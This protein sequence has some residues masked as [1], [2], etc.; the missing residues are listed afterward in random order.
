MGLH[1]TGQDVRLVAEPVLRKRACAHVLNE[2]PLAAR[3]A[4]LNDIA[5]MVA[6]GCS[7]LLV[8]EAGVGKSRLLRAALD[9]AASQAF[10]AQVAAAHESAASIF[11]SLHEWLGLHASAERDPGVDHPA[12]YLGRE[13][14]GHKIIL[15]IDDAHLLHPDIVASLYQ[16]ATFDRV[17]LIITVRPGEPTPE[18]I[19]KLWLDR[20]VERIEIKPFTRSAVG[21]VLSAKL[22]SHV[23]VE[24]VKRM[25]MMTGG[26]A[27]LLMELVDH[28]IAEGSLRP[29]NGIWRWAGFLP[30]IEGRLVEVVRSRLGDL[31]PDEAELIH[32][33]ALAESLEIDL[34]VVS[35]LT[36]AAESL[37]RRGVMVAERCGARLNVRLAYPL[38]RHVLAATMP[39]LTAYRLRLRLT[40]AI[41]QTER[42]SLD[43]RPSPSPA[44]IVQVAQARALNLVLGSHRADKALTVIDDALKVLSEVDARPLYA[45]QARFRILDDRFR[46][47]AAVGEALLRQ[48]QP[49]SELMQAMAPTVAF[50]HNAL[51]DSQKAL[52]LLDQCHIVLP[53]W[54]DQNWQRHQLV[55]AQATLMAGRCA[56]AHAVLDGLRQR[57]IADDHSAEYMWFILV[58]AQLDR[59]RGR[60]SDAAEQFRRASRLSIKADWLTSRVWILA[61][62]AGT[63][64][65]AGRL[66]E[67]S[68]TLSEARVSQD[69]TSLCPMDVDGADLESAV[70]L[71]QTDQR[72]HAAILARKVAQRCATAGRLTQAISALHLAA[73]V[74][75]ARFVVDRCAQLASSVSSAVLHA[76]ADHVLALANDDADALI[77]IGD[78]FAQFDM[79]PLAAEAAAQSCAAYRKTRRLHSARIAAARCHR[80]L[81]SYDIRLPAWVTFGTTPAHGSSLGLTAREHEI[82]GYAAT[83]LSNREIADRLT[84]SVRT[85]EN[86]LQRTYNKLGIST[87]FDLILNLDPRVSSSPGTINGATQR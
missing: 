62:L 79:R 56:E 28:A 31:R 74:G 68:R 66:T 38:Y 80:L 10:I 71:A 47:A 85:V 20:L 9:R 24:T 22:G 77:E 32:L 3:E 49:Q 53:A 1:C 52:D 13:V 73:R 43:N 5:N 37:N 55:M 39:T 60:H 51:G 40:E 41:E 18:G 59:H 86:H 35:E 2:W 78:R 21:E 33:A 17:T 63:L 6:S 27:L 54:K 46:E 83:G 67:A 76:R 36:H 58:S 48:E 42:N 12:K 26:N 11:P 64:A 82:A 87:R 4:E 7:V 81:T 65:E 44:T 72:D 30:Y 61:Q 25:Q 16:L 34:P 14:T 75:H 8:G 15:G 29:V 19:S 69:Q 70:V 57:M 45:Y 84:V 50:T 23:D